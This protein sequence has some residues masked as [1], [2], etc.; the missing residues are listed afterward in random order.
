MEQNISLYR[1]FYEV[2]QTGNI[3]KA[4]KNL[5]ISQPAISKSI[6]RLEENLDV[7]LF[8]RNSRGVTLTQEGQLLFGYVRSAFDSL[9]RGEDELRRMT[10]L[11][12]GHIRI[13]VSSVLCKYVLLPCLK[14]FIHRYPHVRFTIMNQSTLQ[15]LELLDNHQI[16]LG[17]TAEPRYKQDMV[18]ERVMEIEDGFIATPSYLANMR[19]RE[20]SSRTDIFQDGTI[21]MLEKGNVSRTYT[22][23]YLREQHIEPV[24]T[25]EVSSMD[26]LIDFVRI[27]LGAGCVIKSF[28]ADEIENGTFTEIR[29]DPP[30][31]KRNIGFV[32]SSRAP[33]SGALETFIAF[34]RDFFDIH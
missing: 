11:G 15:T 3:S 31:P 17:L 23:D 24:H 33:R 25:L 14:E 6:S 5:Y 32:Y 30:I 26:L 10:E 12:I 19:I 28:I 9:D 20:R 21:L 7:R 34:Y 16:D 29:M 27:G 4:A 1:V 18:F 8:I 2:A 22:D 13:G